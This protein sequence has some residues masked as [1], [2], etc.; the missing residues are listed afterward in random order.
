MKTKSF[1]STAI[2][3]FVFCN[4]L[5]ADSPITSTDIY[6][7]YKNE[8][9]V[10]E[11]INNSVLTE[12]L[13]E[14]LVSPQN[15]I[16]VKIAVIN[17]LGW[18]VNGKNNA[19]VFF[20]YLNKTNTYKSIADFMQK[21]DGELL[22]CMAYLKAMD[23][24]FD[25]DEAV[26]IA[27][28]VKSKYP[29]SYTVNIVCALIEAQKAMESGDGCEMY[30]LTDRVRENKSLNDDM[31][32]TA[33]TEIFGYM[34]WYRG[35][36]IPYYFQ[37]A[38]IYGNQKNY[39]QVI[40]CYKKIL[41]LNPNDYWANNNIGYS[42]FLIEK[43][44]SAIPYL[45]KAIEIEPNNPFAYSNMG[46]VY[47]ALGNYEKTI[48]YCRKAIDIKDKYNADS[49]GKSSPFDFGEPYCYIGFAY[50][51]QNDWEKSLSYLIEAARLGDEDAR[52]FLEELDRSSNVPQQQR[53][54]QQQSRPQ[55]N[56]LKKDPNFKIK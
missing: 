17:A 18:D 34:N 41:T 51:E 42:Y 22:I 7:G 23:S 54:T 9:I 27:Q 26:L 38:N 53:P 5:F 50:A 49:K 2:L 55:Q 30:Q 15:P 19:D 28:K 43:Y 39:T 11:A 36:C 4:S 16:A 14:Y 47:L 52:V 33:K 40:E 1:L 29:K 24:Y 44:Y 12:K 8:P 56:T 31:N 20:Q 32:E 37:Q 6:S 10:A 35:D 25:V 3:F 13:L 21:A 48:S 46:G 45:Q